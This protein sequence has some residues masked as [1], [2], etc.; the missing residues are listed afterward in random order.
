MTGA[1]P[2]PPTSCVWKWLN[3]NDGSHGLY[4]LFH[5]Q[6]AADRSQHPT[7]PSATFITSRGLLARLVPGLLTFVQEC[8]SSAFACCPQELHRIPAP[9]SN[10]TFYRCIGRGRTRVLQLRKY[11]RLAVHASASRCGRRPQWAQA[12]AQTGIVLSWQISRRLSNRRDKR[13]WVHLFLTINT[14]PVEKSL[15][16]FWFSNV[17]PMEACYSH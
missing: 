13:H 16:L 1:L 15:P 7:P 2:A 12:G 11:N 17:A 10:A 3:G 4:L 6:T 8:P 14:Q 9:P 5:Q